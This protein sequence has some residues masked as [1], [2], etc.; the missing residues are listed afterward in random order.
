MS[1]SAAKD[2]LVY[3]LTNKINGKGYVGKDRSTGMGTKD[4][5]LH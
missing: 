4:E 5:S 1:S 3:K 2:P